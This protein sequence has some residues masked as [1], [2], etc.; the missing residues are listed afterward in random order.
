[1]ATLSATVRC[2]RTQIS[3]QPISG[4]LGT[5]GLLVSGR[6]TCWQ[7]SKHADMRMRTAN[8]ALGSTLLLY[9]TVSG[10]GLSSTAVRCA[11]SCLQPHAMWLMISGAYNAFD[12]HFR[13]PFSYVSLSAAL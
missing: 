10:W 7:R 9:G 5:L 1:M 8:C 2:A 11:V 4:P 3:F 12:V 6:Y 13:N